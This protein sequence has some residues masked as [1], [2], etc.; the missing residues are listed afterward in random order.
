[1]DVAEEE[2][3]DSGVTARLLA[4]SKATKKSVIETIVALNSRS[5]L[6]TKSTRRRELIQSEKVFD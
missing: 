6:T 4:G 2:K 1:M 3:V 5:W